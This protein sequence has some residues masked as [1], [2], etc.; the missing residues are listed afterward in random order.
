MV[1]KGIVSVLLGAVCSFQA[2]GWGQKGHDVTAAIAEAHLTPAAADSVGEIFNGM[3]L[4]Y[5]ANWLD[6]ASHTPRYAYSKTWHYKN[7]DGEGAYFTTKPHPDGDV[8]TALRYNIRQLADT[9]A[10]RP[11]RAL[12]L[13][14]LVHL[15][16][17][18]H[19]PMHLGRA[20]DYGGNTI[21]V[22]YFGRETNLHSVWDSS[23]LESAHRWSYTEWRDQL[24][25]LPEGERLVV[26]GG[27][28]DDWARQ[29][30]ALAG[31]VYGKTPQGKRLYYDDVA[32]WG[33]VIE[34]Q[35]VKGGLRLAHVLNCLFDPVYRASARDASTF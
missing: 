13:K 2:F 16:G 21:K 27:N 6:N 19:Q 23:L 1:C 22:K 10:V 15:M 29:S 30:V 3:S 8:V 5:W 11:D 34:Q 25:R 26:V 4:V 28:I 18:L 33:P 20:A 12:A 35:L 14:M 24:D 9:S 31:E 32:A 7:I 17:D